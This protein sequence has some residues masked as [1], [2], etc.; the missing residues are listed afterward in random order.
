M[1]ATEKQIQFMEI[2][3]EVVGTGNLPKT[4]LEATAW[5]SKNINKYKFQN[6]LDG[7]VF[8]SKHSGWGDR[9]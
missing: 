4:K 6:E 8:E 3:N 9:K 5:I 1:K 7:I 2:I